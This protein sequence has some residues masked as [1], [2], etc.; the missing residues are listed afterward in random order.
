MQFLSVKTIIMSNTH[1]GEPRTSEEYDD[2]TGITIFKGALMI[3]R[4]QQETELVDLGDVVHI[5]VKP[6]AFRK[7]TRG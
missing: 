6:G 7:V 4:F 5:S 2:V 3:E 1:T